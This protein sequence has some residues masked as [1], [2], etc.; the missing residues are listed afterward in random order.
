[1]PTIRGNRTLGAMTDSELARKL[2]LAPDANAA[3]LDERLAAATSRLKDGGL[4]WVAYRKGNVG[5]LNRDSLRTAMAEHAWD[6]IAQ[7]SVDDAW[8]AMRF[9][10]A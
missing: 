3:V 4:L 9:K 2:R 10:R 5:D 8:S 6:S 1:M 7:V